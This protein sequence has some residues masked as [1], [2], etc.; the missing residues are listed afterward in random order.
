MISDLYLRYAFDLFDLND[1][2]E[3]AGEIPLVM[4]QNVLCGA[5]STKKRIDND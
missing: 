2:A 3:K 5:I 1:D 4:L